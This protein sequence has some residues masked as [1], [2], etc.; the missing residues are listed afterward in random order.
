[1]TSPPDRHRATG[2][3]LQFAGLVVVVFGL[4]ATRAWLMPICFALLIA[5]LAEVPLRWLQR[6]GLPRP[7]AAVVAPDRRSDSW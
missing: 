3:F 7:I 6:R 4:Q 5:V 1:M 2:S